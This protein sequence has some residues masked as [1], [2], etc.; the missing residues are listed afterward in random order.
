MWQCFNCDF[1]NVDAAPVCAKC[2]VPKPEEGAAPQGRSYHASQLASQER[3][4]DELR[5]RTL[6]PLPATAKLRERWEK[7]A[8]DRAQMIDELALLDRR[9]YA[10]RE[11]LGTLITVAKQPQARGNETLLNTALSALIDWDQE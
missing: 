2:R 3:A 4:A 7:A 10:V 1:Q 9:L 8:G 6:P 5:T 11:A